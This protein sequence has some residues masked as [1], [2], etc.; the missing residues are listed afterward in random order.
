ML[1]FT[2][3]ES[4]LKAYQKNGEEKMAEKRTSAQKRESFPDDLLS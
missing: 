4:G 2:P 1:Q 3:Y